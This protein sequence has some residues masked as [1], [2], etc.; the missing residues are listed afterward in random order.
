MK[1][2]LFFLFLAL[3]ILSC[4]KNGVQPKGYAG[5]WEM[6]QISENVP[7]API[8]NLTLGEGD[9]LELYADSSTY[10]KYVGFKISEKGPYRIEKNGVTF[11]NNT[12]DAIYY[13]NNT[14]A[15]YIV[16]NGNELTIGNTFPNGYIRKYERRR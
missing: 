9:L 3:T 8:T 2:I 11:S 10:I 4:K 16:L 6:T 14:F 12:Y 5:T 1:N 13:D 7:G 15:D